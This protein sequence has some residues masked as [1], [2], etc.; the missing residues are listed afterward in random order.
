MKAW[1]NMPFLDVYGDGKNVIP[2]IHI[3]DLS[4]I[5]QA[6]FEEQPDSYYI[7]ARDRSESTLAGILTLKA[8]SGVFSSGDIRRMSDDEVAR[9]RG[10]PKYQIDQLTM[11]LVISNVTLQE[12]L[13]IP[14]KC[15]NGMIE[16]I[17]TLAREY[18]EAKEFKPLRICVLGPPFVGK[19]THAMEL[20]RYYGL[21]YI[22]VMP[23]LY[24]AYLRLRKPI[25]ALEEIE[26]AKKLAKKE[27]KKADAGAP[28]KASP[29]LP[30]PPPPPPPRP[31][32]PPQPPL[33]AT[34]T[35]QDVADE[36]LST[37]TFPMSDLM[38]SDHVDAAF[39]Q[40]LPPPTP[41]TV[42]SELPDDDNARPPSEVSLID[43]LPEEVQQRYPFYPPVRWKDEDELVK[44]AN[45]AKTELIDFI[46]GLLDDFHVEDH[47]ITKYLRQKL[48]SKPCCNQGFVLDGYPNSFEQAEM[49]FRSRVGSGGDARHPT[50]DP[51]LFPHHV[52]YLEASNAL[53][54]HRFK[55]MM[56]D[57]GIELDELP[58]YDD[59]DGLTM[60]VEEELRT[61]VLKQQKGKNEDNKGDKKRQYKKGD[62]LKIKWIKPAESSERRLRR[63][64]EK[65]RALMAPRAASAIVEKTFEPYSPLLAKQEAKSRRPRSAASLQVPRPWPRKELPPA[66]LDPLEKNVLT[67]FDLRE[68]HPFVVNMDRDKSQPLYPGGPQKFTFKSILKRIS[69][70]ATGEFV[71]TAR[72]LLDERDTD[73][74]NVQAMK[75][76]WADLE[77]YN[78][79]LRAE[80]AEV[81]SK[82]EQAIWHDW[83]MLL[84]KENEQ[85][86]TV[87]S[88]P[89]RNYLLRYVLPVVTECL[90][91]YGQSR[92]T[93]PVE[94][95]VEYLLRTTGAAS[96]G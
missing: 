54:T 40:A 56:A 27:K 17:A 96:K 35:S 78:D 26:K 20:A 29:P 85:L 64:L 67:Y 59:V 91:L 57:E 51:L 72:A 66:Q 25:K 50:F 1:M 12:A 38:P 43:S 61:R 21:H 4:M 41:L 30:P 60:D 83:L 28:A 52:V 75:K 46:N 11:D 45:E 16:N 88:M 93:D 22:H 13:T 31:P 14:W 76:Q 79:E 3:K 42:F 55:K 10:I 70:S 68:L 39:S 9:I 23:V 81:L 95:L 71:R 53:V 82:R 87:K 18:V 84:R 74:R 49:L 34:T 65:H 69:K 19:T 32:P 7:V 24:E 63:R 33:L 86:H 6:V 5:A 73:E 94:F 48:L 92:P 80:A 77:D 2:T 36:H 15:E 89:R 44:M 58:D 8:I 62:E 47:I 90:V 37:M